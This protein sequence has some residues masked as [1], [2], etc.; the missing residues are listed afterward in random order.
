MLACYYAGHH[1]RSCFPS[2]RPKP[3][4]I[5]AGVLPHYSQWLSPPACVRVDV[6]HILAVR[7]DM[8]LKCQALVA[9]SSR[10][11]PHYNV[12]SNFWIYL[13]GCAGQISCARRRGGRSVTHVMARGNGP[14]VGIAGSTQTEQSKFPYRFVCG[15]KCFHCA[16]ARLVGRACILLAFT[17]KTWQSCLRHEVPTHYIQ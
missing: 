6:A 14:N 12:C 8:T 9:A 16:D 13:A 4:K 2:A 3:I 7:Q 11:P 5:Q 15:P 17:L 1:K 10:R